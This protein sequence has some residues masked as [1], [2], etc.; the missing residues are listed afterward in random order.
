MFY[1]CLMNGRKLTEMMG[2][3][4]G[5][6][7]KEKRKPELGISMCPTAIQYF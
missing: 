7:A 5:M 6:V 1:K 2:E 4:K 3:G